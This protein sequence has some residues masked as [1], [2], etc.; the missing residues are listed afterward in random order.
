[1]GG[2]NPRWRGHQPPTQALFGENICKNERIW[3]CWGPFSH[4]KSGNVIP[5]TCLE[6]RNVIVLR[7]FYL[8]VT[9]PS[10]ILRTK[11]DTV[12]GGEILTHWNIVKIA[13][14][15]VCNEFWI[16]GLEME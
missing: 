10:N 13:T 1:M 6:K 11:M 3:S 7:N 4:Y 15:N 12:D 2:T 9:K 16:F 8:F 14:K 5:T